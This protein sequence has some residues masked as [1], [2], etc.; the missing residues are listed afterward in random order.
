MPSF[1]LTTKAKTQSGKIKLNTPPY[2]A[3]H[4]II[5]I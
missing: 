5:I 3:H 4:M 2:T 1:A